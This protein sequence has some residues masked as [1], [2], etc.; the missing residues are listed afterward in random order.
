MEGKLKGVLIHP[1]TARELQEMLSWYRRQIAKER[2]NSPIYLPYYG[3]IGVL[4]DDC[5][6]GS[7][8][9]ATDVAI[10]MV[11]YTDGEFV[12]T[13]IEYQVKEIGMIADDLSEGHVVTTRNMGGAMIIDGASC[14]E[15]E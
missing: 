12:E 11:T 3:Y 14:N 13:G 2:N 4:Q 5:P 7:F 15:S 6:K 10:N 8:A 1:E 9:T